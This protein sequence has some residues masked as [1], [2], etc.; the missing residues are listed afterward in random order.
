MAM[1]KDCKEVFATVDMVNGRCKECEKK[2]SNDYKQGMPYA[3]KEVKKQEGEANVF[4]IVVFLF[5]LM[6]IFSFI[7]GGVVLYNATSA[8]HQILGYLSI[9]GGTIFST[10]AGIINAINTKEIKWVK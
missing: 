2:I 4:S 7:D 1:C 5:I 3:D 6:A 10:A 8:I 9:I